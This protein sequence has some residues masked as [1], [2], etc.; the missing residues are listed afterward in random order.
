MAMRRFSRLTNA[1]SKKVE[2]HAHGIALHYMHYSC[3][4]QRTLRITS[5]MQTGWANRVWDL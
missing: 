2:H 4:F 3:R 5:A 1:F